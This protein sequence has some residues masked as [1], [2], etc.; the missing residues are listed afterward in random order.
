MARPFSAIASR[1]TNTPSA[2]PWAV[3][4][5]LVFLQ[6]CASAA[7]TVA[8]PLHDMPVLAGEARAELRLR[9]DLA[10][11]QRCEE[12]FDLALYEDRAIDLVAWDDATGCSARAVSIRYLAAKRT[13]AQ[14]LERVRAIAARAEPIPAS[15]APAKAEP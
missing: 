2:R 15:V 1:M 7:A 6:G 13:E 4:A 10:P 8:G 12:A 11:G 3:L 5:G 14:L 9:V